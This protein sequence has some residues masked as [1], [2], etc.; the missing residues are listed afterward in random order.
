MT[1]AS[2]RVAALLVVLAGCASDAERGAATRPRSLSP[3]LETGLVALFARAKERGLGARTRF[4]LFVPEEEVDRRQLKGFR[5]ALE[6]AA[7]RAGAEHGV[8]YL[9]SA[10]TVFFVSRRAD[11]ELPPDVDGTVLANEFRRGTATGWTAMHTW[12]RQ[13]NRLLVGDRDWIQGLPESIRADLSTPLDYLVRV[14]VGAPQVSDGSVHDHDVTFELVAVGS[15]ETRASARC[16]IVLTY[17]L[18]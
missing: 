17:P 9:A 10:E 12:W 2:A 13:L 5:D 16:Q 14:G 8:Q 7:R 4:A 11:L 3:Q 1:S 15:E 18:R 6:P